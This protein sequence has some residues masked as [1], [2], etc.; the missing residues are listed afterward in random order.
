MA[1]QVEFNL[2]DI[3]VGVKTMAMRQTFHPVRNWLNG[4]KWDGIARLD[5]WLP[6]IMG[7]DDNPYTRA[8]GSI[9]LMGA[10]AR[11]F[12]PGCKFDYMLVLEGDQGLKKTQT[13]QALAGN[14]PQLYCSAG[15]RLENATAEKDTVAIMST[16]MF[17]EI[18]ELVMATQGEIDQMKAFVTRQ[19]DKVRLPFT[20]RPQNIPRQC[21]FIGTT[22]PEN[23]AGYLRDRTGAR[24]FWPV[25]CTKTDLETLNAERDQ[26]FAEAKERWEAGGLLYMTPDVEALAK[27]EQKER[28]QIDPWQDILDGHVPTDRVW[29]TQEIY[30]NILRCDLRYLGPK[31]QRR[32]AACMRNLGFEYGKFFH[33]P[34]GERRRA[35]K[36]KTYDPKTEL[37]KI[38]QDPD[39]KTLDNFVV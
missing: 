13:V 28:E 38:L 1:K 21:V 37:D 34:S 36:A 22:N 3:E 23:G 31:E 35:F 16:A 17:V 8:A 5:T 20:R 33:A 14:N 12:K 19:T 39:K 6:R 4:L 7:T 2:N 10:V 9:T 26:L 11:C 18:A 29:T 30:V 32:V 24:R 25:H 27:V 15:I